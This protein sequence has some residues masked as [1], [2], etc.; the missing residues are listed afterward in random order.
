MAKY[1]GPLAGCDVDNL[2]MVF[3]KSSIYDY[4]ILGVVYFEFLAIWKASKNNSKPKR[5]GKI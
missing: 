3:F 2:T 5:S 1:A 4:M